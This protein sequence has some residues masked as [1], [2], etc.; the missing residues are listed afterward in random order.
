MNYKKII[1]TLDYQEFSMDYQIILNFSERVGLVY[2]HLPSTCF[3][4]A[5]K[6]NINHAYRITLKHL[7]LF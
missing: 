6:E 3:V 1:F 5:L 7:L 4:F 2:T